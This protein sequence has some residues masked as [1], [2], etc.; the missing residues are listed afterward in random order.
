MQGVPTRWQWPQKQVET[1]MC[2]RTQEELG[3]D[4]GSKSKDIIVRQLNIE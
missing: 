2:T 4:I 3:N 1:G